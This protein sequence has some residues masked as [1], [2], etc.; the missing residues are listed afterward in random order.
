MFVSKSWV[1]V[2]FCAWLTAAGCGGS[3]CTVVGL[4]VAPP[5]ATVSHVAPGNSQT[6]VSSTLFGGGNRP[7]PANASM[8]VS[9]NWTVSDPSVQLSSSPAS[10]VTAT[11]TTALVGPVTVTATSND[12][13]M[14][15]GRASL[16]CN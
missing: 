9:A 3:G 13:Q 7:C 2:F 5:T 10:T 12:S 15:T 14:L 16:T 1:G 8:L 6:F 4:N 11:C